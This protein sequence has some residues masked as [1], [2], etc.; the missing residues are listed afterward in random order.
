VELRDFGQL[1]KQ[2]PALDRFM[3][4]N[5][6][7]AGC[8]EAVELLRVYAELVAGDASAGPGPWNRCSSASLWSVFRRHRGASRCGRR[9]D[10]LI[11]GLIRCAE[12][13][14]VGHRAL[15][16]RATS[17]GTPIHDVLGGKRVLDSVG[18]ESTLRT[19]QIIGD[20]RGQ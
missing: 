14:R 11:T 6:R 2:E 17:E 16:Q 9:L 18:P 4:T 7:D 3:E 12:G 5:P 15:I 13:G 10:D 1:M 20:L 8:E 19:S